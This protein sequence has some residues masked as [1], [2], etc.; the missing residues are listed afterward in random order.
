[1]VTFGIIDKLQ[2]IDSN[3]KSNNRI[4]AQKGVFVFGNK[5]IDNAEPNTNTPFWAKIR[6][7]LLKLLSINCNLSH[8]EKILLSSFGWVNLS[9]SPLLDIYGFSMVND[10]KHP[11]HKKTAEEYFLEGNQDYQKGKFEEAIEAYKK[12]IEVEPDSYGAY[13]NMGSAYAEL[14]KFEK[15]IKVC[16]KAIKIKPDKDQAYY[17]MGGAYAELGKFEKALEV[18]KKAIEVKPDSY[19]AYNNMGVA[20]AGLDELKKALEAY[21]KAIEIMPDDY[22]TYSNMGIAYAGLGEFEK[23]I[24]VC[25]KAIKIKPEASIASS[26]LSNPA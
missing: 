16:K 4:F 14:G 11:I 15:A 20:Y 12:A 17:N 21:K 23:T 19:E 13:N 22:E 24:E 18:C 26:N 8:S 10:V 9:I 25:K 2:F 5:T 3:F 7:L 6:L 1:M